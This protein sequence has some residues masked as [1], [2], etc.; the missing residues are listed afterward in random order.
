VSDPLRGGARILHCIAQARARCASD[1]HIDP[2]EGV[3]FRIFTAMERIAA[4]S[5][6]GSDV[7]AFLELALDRLSRARFEKIGIAD[8]AYADSDVGAI[9]IH[10]SRGSHGSRLAIRLLAKSVPDLDSLRLPAVVES[11]IRFRSGL[12]LIVGPPGCGKS[13]TAAALIQRVN[14][15]DRRHIVT[16]EAPVE[17]RHRWDKSVVTQY[18]VGRDVATFAAGVQGALRADPDLLF[19]ADLQGIDT[20]AAALR[21]AEAGHLVLAALHTPSESTHAVNRIV[22]L[23]P[24]EEQERIRARLAETLRAILAL[25]LLPSRAGGFQPAAEILLATD[26]VRRL[27]RDGASHQLHST[28]AS[29]R[30]D[31]AQTLEAHLAELVAAGEIDANIAS[32][33]TLYPEELRELTLQ[34]KR[35]A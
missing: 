6:D 19:I 26:A 9:R 1:V 12:V 25:R 11:F 20:T 14:E 15:S 13:T 29:S 35:R 24:T 33:E 18:E 3:A 17:H 7:E 31:G 8:A 2:A 4:A 27:I 28:L 22:G 32:A 5:I 23:F 30:K 21:A 34:A 10:A 16:L